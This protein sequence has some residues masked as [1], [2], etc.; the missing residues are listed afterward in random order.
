MVYYEL[1]AKHLFQNNKLENINPTLRS[2]YSV[3]TDV[4]TSHIYPGR[5]TLL[6]KPETIEQRRLG[7][8]A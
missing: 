7:S 1:A 2:T 8:S 6:L 3:A 4:K 5:L